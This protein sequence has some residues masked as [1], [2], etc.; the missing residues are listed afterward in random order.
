MSQQGRMVWNPDKGIYEPEEAPGKYL[1][2]TMAFN[3]STQIWEPRKDDPT[4]PSNSNYSK[5]AGKNMV[6][7][8]WSGQ[9][10]QR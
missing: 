2:G 6:Y 4:N 3:H 7:D 1:T 9:W 8:S 10:K 5:N